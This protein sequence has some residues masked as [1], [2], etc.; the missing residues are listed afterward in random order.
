M[1]ARFDIYSLNMDPVV[2]KEAKNTR[3]C[4][5]VSPD[6]MNQNLST[7]IVAPVSSSSAKYPTR[8]TVTLLNSERLIV[9][10]QLR[11]VDK[12]RLAK[13]IGSLEAAAQKE[14]LDRLQELFAE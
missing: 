10:D 8:I 6:E 7:V 4:V 11:T 3:P 14:V 9:L 13:K 2:G 5:V 1:V 12:E